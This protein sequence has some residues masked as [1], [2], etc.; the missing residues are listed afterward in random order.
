MLTSLNS[1]NSRKDE[2]VARLCI[3][4]TDGVSD[5][6]SFTIDSAEKVKEDGIE[7]FSIGIGTG[8]NQTELEE[9]A[10][11]EDFVSFLDD[12]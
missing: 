4:L 6:P 12:F 2:N 10:S 3:L 8:I 5:N 9:A 11:K 1:T 7:I